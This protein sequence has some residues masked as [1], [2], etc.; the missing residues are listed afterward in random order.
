[1]QVRCFGGGGGEVWEECRVESYVVEGETERQRCEMTRFVG[2]EA[3]SPL[4]A[5]EVHP[6]HGVAA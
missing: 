6:Y 5:Q 4:V 3:S 2:Q 1:M